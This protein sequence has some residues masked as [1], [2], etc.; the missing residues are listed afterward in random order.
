MVICFDSTFHEDLQKHIPKQNRFA[1]GVLGQLLDDKQK[2]LIPQ[3]MSVLEIPEKRVCNLKHFGK[4][5]SAQEQLDRYL[6]RFL[7][8]IRHED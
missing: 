1:L 3:E 8:L 5:C 4:I 2:N 6:A 7:V